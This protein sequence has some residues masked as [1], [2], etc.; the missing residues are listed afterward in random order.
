MSPEQSR[1]GDLD[2]RT[3]LYSLGCILYELLAEQPPFTG[4]SPTSILLAHVQ[5]DVR[6][7]GE[8]ASRE[9]PDRLEDLV[10]RLL[11]KEPNDRPQTAT[12]VRQTLG[13]ILAEQSTPGD[14]RSETSTEAE[15]TDEQDE[16]G[17]AATLGAESTDER[18]QS[19]GGSSRRVSADDK[20]TPAAGAAREVT[21]E[22]TASSLLEAN[23]GL[24]M[25]AIGLLLVVCVGVGGLSVYYVFSEQKE[26]DVQPAVAE[27]TEVPSGSTASSEANAGEDAAGSGH[28]EETAD[29]AASPGP[30]GGSDARE[31]APR[32]GAKAGDEAEDQTGGASG[33][34]QDGSSGRSG[35]GR[36]SDESGDEKTAGAGE[37]PAG[38]SESPSLEEA[39][40][41]VVD[42]EAPDESPSDEA[43]EPSNGERESSEEATGADDSSGSAPNPA[44][45]VRRA[46]L[47]IT[48]P[49]CSREKIEGRLDERMARL[50]ECY[51]EEAN[52]GGA[53][54]S[55]DVL[56]EWNISTDGTVVDPA[57]LTSSLGRPN[58][59]TCLEQRLS[60]LQFPAPEGGRCYTRAKFAF[61][62]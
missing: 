26:A 46:S 33:S 56:L 44:S 40:E 23:R 7:L 43:A 2:G 19:D 18:I 12:E 59:E 29:V 41:K 30:D 55:G 16:V 39:R 1:D 34:E 15:T 50:G 21:R 60:N 10:V 9:I 52:G 53:G 6:P 31:A 4:D 25:L 28:P 17:R 8:V 3:D 48:G 45:F 5:R 22:S 20:P 13:D 54:P 58:I 32:A 49:V 62:K 24:L 11:E 61:G 42:S 36:E 51:S 27:R 35:G 57:V 38:E 14:P 47:S 37:S